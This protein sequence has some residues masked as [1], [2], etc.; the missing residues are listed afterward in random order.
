MSEHT[1]RHDTHAKSQDED[2]DDIR[3]RRPAGGGVGPGEPDEDEFELIGD[4]DLGATDLGPLGP[5]AHDPDAGSGRMRKIT[6]QSRRGS[7]GQ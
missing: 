3:P 4:N 5:N 6:R 7:R 1:A 2:V